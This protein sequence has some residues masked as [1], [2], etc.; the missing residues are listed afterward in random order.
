MSEGEAKKW[1]GRTMSIGNVSTSLDGERLPNCRASEVNFTDAK[2]CQFEVQNAD[3]REWIAPGSTIIVGKNLVLT[4]WDG[5]FF[6]LQKGAKGS[7][8]TN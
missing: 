3:G 1:I 4:C 6:V 5:V 8:E 2:V 7:L